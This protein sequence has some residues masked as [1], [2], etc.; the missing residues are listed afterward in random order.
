[1]WNCFSQFFSSVLVCIHEHNHGNNLSCSS[2][3][4][5][6]Y[7]AR[8]LNV[9]AQT[10]GGGLVQR[11]ERA[12]QLFRSLPVSGRLVGPT[13]V[14]HKSSS[15]TPAQDLANYS[16]TYTEPTSQRISWMSQ[17]CLWKWW[18]V[19]KNVGAKK[20]NFTRRDVT[21]WNCIMIASFFFDRIYSP[22][23]FFP[24]IILFRPMA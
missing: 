18:F 23:V 16:F 11:G 22:Q 8:S 2:L 5:L 6:V 24:D 1:M 12:L 14:Q 9:R 17:S 19:T 3:R 13:L 4:L 20:K 10:I 7:Y 21:L 15:P